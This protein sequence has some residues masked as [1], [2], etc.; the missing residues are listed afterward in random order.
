MTNQQLAEYWNLSQGLPCLQ[1]GRFKDA[2]A[3]FRQSLQCNPNYAEAH[4][5]LG[6][7][8]SKQGDV[9]GA[10][11]CFQR[12]AQLKPDFAD[13][14]FNLGLM[15]ARAGRMDQA[16][17]CHQETVRLNPNHAE[18]H[19]HLALVWLMDGNYEQGWPALA[20][21]WH[22]AGVLAPPE[23]KPSWQSVENPKKY[24]S[25]ERFGYPPPL[26]SISE[27]LV[28]VS[29]RP[30]TCFRITDHSPKPIW[31]IRS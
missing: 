2:E 13:A 24:G 20:W 30:A 27:F 21:R 3:C 23:R 25:F 18:A 12:A 7:A 5:N 28:R 9:Q 11:A 8:L 22:R 16:V 15:F 10:A 1:Q 31:S 6:S 17:A 19:T 4:N 14:Y 26:H 29:P